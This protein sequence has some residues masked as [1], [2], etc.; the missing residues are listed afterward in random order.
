MPGNAGTIIFEGSSSAI[1][2]GELFEDVS[3]AWTTNQV[4]E[5]QG[6]EIRARTDDANHL[7][8]ANLGEFGINSDL[9]EDNT[10][11]FDVGEIM[12]LSFDK[13]VR[14]DLLDFNRFDSNDAFSVEVAGQNDVAIGYDDLDNKSSDFIAFSPGIAI[15]ADTEVRFYASAGTIGLDSMDVTVIP[16]P[17]VIGFVSLAGIGALLAKRFV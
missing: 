6:L 14:I 11:A 2:T 13:P 10:E 16:E 9:A 7:L 4:A 17:A 15:A 3:N 1:T 8:N 12:V 5:F